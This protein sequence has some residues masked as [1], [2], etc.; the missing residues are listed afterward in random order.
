[1][2][3]HAIAHAAERRAAEDAARQPAP[4][5]AQAVQRPHA[6]H[7]VEL[8]A[9]LRE[10]EHGD[11]DGAR[12]AAH[13]QRAGRMHDVG[14]RADGHQPGERAVVRE[15]RIVLA[16][17]NRCQRAAD[18]RHQRIERHQSANLV[19]GLR[20]HHIKAKPAYRQNPGAEREKRNA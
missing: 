13:D 11:E 17:Q 16:D 15:A 19:E 3:A 1:M 8:P 7:V 5:A 10:R 14:A 4:R 6:E 2:R 20:T 9:V 12:H 18:H